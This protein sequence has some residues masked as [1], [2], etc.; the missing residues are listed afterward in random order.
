MAD[1]DQPPFHPQS[2]RTGARDSKMMMFV[3]AIDESVIHRIPTFANIG[4]NVAML[5]AVV[6][7]VQICASAVALAWC[8]R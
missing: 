4:H 3:P 8:C 2:F 7:M 5:G 6:L 1:S